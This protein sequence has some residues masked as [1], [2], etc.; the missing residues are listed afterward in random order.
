[1]CSKKFWVTFSKV[2]GLNFTKIYAKKNSK[3]V[4][5]KILRAKETII[6]CYQMNYY[7]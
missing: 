3:R 1:V 2:F 6:F 7:N 5:Q 4:F